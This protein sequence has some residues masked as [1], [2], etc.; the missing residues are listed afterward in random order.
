MHF[1]W[2]GLKGLFAFPTIIYLEEGNKPGLLSATLLLIQLSH[3]KGGEAPLT[4]V[5]ALFCV[6]EN[7][8]ICFFRNK[9]SELNQRA[10]HVQSHYFEKYNII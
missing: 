8:A 1:T 10:L 6:R 4:S 9:Q 3:I 2:L 7:R 5:R